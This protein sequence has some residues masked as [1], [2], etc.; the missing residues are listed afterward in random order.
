[1]PI[2][3]PRRVCMNHQTADPAARTNNSARSSGCE[4]RGQ[5]TWDLQRADQGECTVIAVC[6]NSS[7][8]NHGI[9]RI[10]SV[11]S[12]RALWC[13]MKPNG[14]QEDRADRGD[15]DDSRDTPGRCAARL[16]RVPQASP[17]RRATLQQHARAEQHP[18]Q[19]LT[20]T[21]RYHGQ[22]RNEASVGARSKR[23]RT[24]GPSTSTRTA[25]TTA[26]PP[27]AHRH[28][29]QRHGDT[30]GRRRASAP[31]TPS[32]SGPVP[33]CSTGTGNVAP[34][35]YWKLGSVGR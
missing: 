17:P 26:E 15:T 14:T 6:G 20:P 18:E 32:K 25:R 7:R 12:P 19:R 31:R 34:S 29:C 27:S 3:R 35:G 2:E 13:E 23:S 8:R 5:G 10:V 24:I 4:V 22:G 30:R 21:W 28:R 11:S 9:A 33:G 16:W 1:M